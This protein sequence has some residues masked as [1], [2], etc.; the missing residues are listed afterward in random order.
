MS[1]A[2][3]GRSPVLMRARYQV[4]GISAI[5]SESSLSQSSRRRS[6]SRSISTSGKNL[7]RYIS[8][9]RSF[10]HSVSRSVSAITDGVNRARTISPSSRISL[11]RSFARESSIRWCSNRPQSSLKHC[12][13]NL[14]L[15]SATYALIS[16][17]KY[18]ASWPGGS[19]GAFSEPQY[20]QRPISVDRLKT[21][22]RRSR[23]PKQNGQQNISDLGRIVKVVG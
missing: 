10:S 9:S 14:P 17:S 13:S 16:N 23:S 21:F 6:R 19:N 20:E 22:F 15:S 4:L 12:T 1:S 7:F 5:S 8:S 3:N 18:S 2:V 11:N